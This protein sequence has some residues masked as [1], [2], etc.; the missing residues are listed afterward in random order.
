MIKDTLVNIYSQGSFS[1]MEDAVFQL[2]PSELVF[3]VENI[4]VCGF[5]ADENRYINE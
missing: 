4:G 3:E 2:I 1:I 5:L